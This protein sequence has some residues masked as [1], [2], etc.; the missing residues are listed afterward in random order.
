MAAATFSAPTPANP[1]FVRPFEGY[2]GPEARLLLF[3]CDGLGDANAPEAIARLMADE[4]DHVTMAD[5]LNARSGWAIARESVNP[6]ARGATTALPQRP[7]S[8][9]ARR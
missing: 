8:Q 6:A 2:Y 7:A 5:D 3:I 1:D 4:T 9:G